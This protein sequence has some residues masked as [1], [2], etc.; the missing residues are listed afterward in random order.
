M[1]TMLPGPVPRNWIHV[2]VM[3]NQRTA[4][5]DHMCLRWGHNVGMRIVEMGDGAG[6]GSR[7]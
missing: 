7:R 2:C 3:L 1:S 5:T 4:G 6:V